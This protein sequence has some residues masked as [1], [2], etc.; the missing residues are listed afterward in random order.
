MSQHALYLCSACCSHF[1]KLMPSTSSGRWQ[2]GLCGVRWSWDCWA[3][4]DPVPH[5]LYSSACL[6]CKQEGLWDHPRDILLRFLMFLTASWKLIQWD[7]LMGH[8]S[9]LLTWDFQ[10]Q[11]LEVCWPS[12]ASPEK[13]T[14]AT[15]QFVNMLISFPKT[16]IHHSDWNLLNLTIVRCFSQLP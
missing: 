15:N 13:T 8:T 2:W 11:S 5:S 12:K 16:T 4:S 10:T 7:A 6:L 14:T 1:D 9:V 3:L